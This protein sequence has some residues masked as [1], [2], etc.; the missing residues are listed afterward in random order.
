MDIRN[1]Y[2][3]R[4]QFF[5]TPN[6]NSFKKNNDSNNFISEPEHSLWGQS[7]LV[8]SSYLILMRAFDIGKLIM[9]AMQRKKQS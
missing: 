7:V 2:V 4:P 5:L 9:C 3:F 1:Y 8:E 6:H